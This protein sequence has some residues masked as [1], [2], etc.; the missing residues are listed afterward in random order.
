MD[1]ASISS[2]TTLAYQITVTNDGNVSLTNPSIQDELTQGN[3][4][5]ALSTGLT[6]SG[7]TDGDGEIDPT[8]TWVYEGTFNVTQD[9]IDNGRDIE[10]EVKFDVSEAK[11][12]TDD[13]A[14]AITQ[15]PS[16]EISKTVDQSNLT[17]PGTLTYQVTVTNTG[18]AT[19]TGVFFGDEVTQ[20]GTVIALASGPTLSGDTNNN[21]DLEVSET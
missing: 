1:Q 13:V 20:D 11:S 10:N 9:E 17:A 16:F 18:N 6:L 2:P 4:K 21:S 5:L 12:Q 8:E 14:T 15:Q 3:T 7:D 19:L